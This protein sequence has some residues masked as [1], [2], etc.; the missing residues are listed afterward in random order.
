[1]PRPIYFEIHADHPQR[2]I[3]FYSRIFGWKVEKW[4]GP[5]DYWLVS[6]G[7]P[8]LPGINGGIMKRRDPRG[9]V[10]NSIEVSSVDDYASKVETNGG[11]IVVPKMA[12]PGMGNLAYCQDTEGTVFG[13][14]QF[15][16]SAG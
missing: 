8:D 16:T 7:D 6:T 10:Y 2:A 12:I 11:K 3:D 15:D 5:E 4:N 1:M 13:I 9:S 14:V